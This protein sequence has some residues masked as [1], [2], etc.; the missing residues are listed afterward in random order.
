[1]KLIP[2]KSKKKVSK[3]I[4]VTGR[5]VPYSFLHVCVIYTFVI[6]GFCILLLVYPLMLFLK[7]TVR[8]NVFC[9]RFYCPLLTQ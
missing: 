4:T 1:M 6:V 2:H 9:A 5:G 3:A 7:T 8:K